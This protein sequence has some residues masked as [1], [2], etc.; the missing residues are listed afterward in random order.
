[1]PS[2]KDWYLTLYYV[3]SLCQEFDA[4][5]NT[6]EQGKHMSLT[7]RIA[8]PVTSSAQAPRPRAS[9]ATVGFRSRVLPAT[10]P[11]GDGFPSAEGT[12]GWFMALALPVYHMGVVVVSKP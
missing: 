1:M 12:W 9:S 4:P 10:A 3:V 8:I 6:C 5:S 2:I 7:L 11:T